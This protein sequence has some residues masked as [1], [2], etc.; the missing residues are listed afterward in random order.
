MYKRIKD[1]REDSDLTQ[2]DVA[3]Y[4]KCTQACYSYYENGTRDIPIDVLI[5]LAHLHKTSTDYLLE[6]TNQ[7]SPYPKK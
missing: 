7:K 3:N 2:T 1:L 5:K 6:L 4:L